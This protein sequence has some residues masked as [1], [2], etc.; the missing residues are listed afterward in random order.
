MNRFLVLCLPLLLG[1]QE[2]S[3][4]ASSQPL[5]SPG[6]QLAS[7]LDE[8]LQRSDWGRPYPDWLALH[9]GARCQ[10]FRAGRHNS[11]PRR[12]P[13][14]WCYRCS[15]Q[16][17]EIAAEVA[18]YPEAGADGGSPSCRLRYAAFEGQAPNH[19]AN[20][21]EELKGRL[22]S[23]YGKSERKDW[24]SFGTSNAFAGLILW[25]T[26]AQEVRAF[27]WRPD[28]LMVEALHANLL[29]PA[30]GGIP[31]QED[32]SD[33]AFLA[34]QDDGWAGQD[35]QEG[36]FRQVIEHGES[37]LKERPGTRT[38]QVL[39]DVAQAYETWWSLSRDTGEDGIVPEPALFEP[40][41][42]RARAA[43]IAGYERLI[44]V[45]PESW[46]AATARH[47]L[48]YLRLGIDT[49]Q[50]RFYCFSGC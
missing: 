2:P 26:P 5:P 3:K 12:L 8:G 30:E 1:V 11:G 35:G 46:Q 37:F 28:T 23:R 27:V 31:L 45:E 25:P 36:C 40:G 43:A 19:V 50:R 39:F 41:A 33:E 6:I 47:Q 7:S 44:Q 17:G 42:D 20:A 9:P 29:K 4:V 48:L 34:L 18:F 49:R 15:F 21:Y 14:G 10:E 22:T 24:R 16:E 13:D 32:W 38:A